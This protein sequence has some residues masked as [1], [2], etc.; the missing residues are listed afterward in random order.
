MSQ[1]KYYIDDFKVRNCTQYGEYEI[2]DNLIS[3]DE[4]WIE[5]DAD[6]K[7]IIVN[8]PMKNKRTRVVIG[9]KQIGE[10]EVPEQMRKILVPLLQGKY[11][12][13]PFVCKINIADKK[14]VI[15]ER[16]QVSVWAANGEAGN[17]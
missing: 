8:G 14:V 4:V 13:Q 12:Y 15:N 3:G 11:G 1:K 10:L 9:Q 17:D 6:E 7:V 2:I 5:Y 16:L